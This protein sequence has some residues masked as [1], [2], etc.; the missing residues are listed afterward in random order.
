MQSHIEALSQ[1]IV[2]EKSEVHKETNT[3]NIFILPFIELLGYDTKNPRGVSQEYKADLACNGDCADLV[4]LQNGKPQIVMECKHHTTNLGMSAIG[5]LSKYFA[6][7]PS[8][9]LGILTNGIDYSFFTDSRHK[10]LM[11]QE[12]FFSF[13]LEHPETVRIE[14]L[15]LFLKQCYTSKLLERVSVI[16]RI[17][18]D[19]QRE[20]S[21]P[22]ADIACMLWGDLLC[23]KKEAP[24]SA[25]NRPENAA[26]DH[27]RILAYIRKAVSGIVESEKVTTKRILNSWCS[28]KIDGV[29]NLA[30]VQFSERGK[31]WLLMNSIGFKR[32][33]ETLSDIS[34]FGDQLREA[35][36][37][38]LQRKG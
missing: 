19:M 18:G 13:N 6:A 17:K 4:I 27:E 1:K 25:S 8:A 9:K 10:N 5:Q 22:A 34:N 30:E 28:I 26:T 11:D 16:N 29:G 36:K 2:Q 38:M 14:V 20:L 31:K 21:L 35:A 32:N 37:L 33:I 23:D 24:P 7:L 12:P 15:L 3:I